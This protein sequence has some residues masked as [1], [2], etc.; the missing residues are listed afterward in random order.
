VVAS[1]ALRMQPVVTRMLDSTV[2]RISSEAQ[3][4]CGL[5]SNCLALLRTNGAPPLLLQIKDVCQLLRKK[6]YHACFDQGRNCTRIGFSARNN[7]LRL[8]VSLVI[9]AFA[10]WLML[11]LAMLPP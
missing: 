4:D 7:A 2:R 11:G 6:R 9:A 8:I 10:G 3:V 1:M 5:F